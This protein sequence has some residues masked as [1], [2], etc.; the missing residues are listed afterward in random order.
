MKKD[1]LTP[2]VRF[3]A[4]AIMLGLFVLVPLFVGAQSGVLFIQD[5]K[6]GIGTDTPQTL[7]DVVGAGGEVSRTR[8]GAHVVERTDGNA[9][10]IRFKVDNATKTQSWLFMNG[11]NNGI[12]T[13]YDETAGKSAFVAYPNSVSYTLVLRGGKVGVGT[14]TPQAPLD[15]NGAIYQRGV[16]LHA[17]Y[18]FNPDYNL[19]SIEEHTAT[20]WKNKHLPALPKA[21]VDD[22]GLEVINVGQHR[23][24]MLE[25]LEKA[26]VYIAELHERL[27]DKERHIGSLEQ[28]VT[29]L[30]EMLSALA[31]RVDTI[32]QK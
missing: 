9:A 16:E 28:K 29:R 27:S 24:G 12:F 14:N 20:M 8:E 10:N 6:V 7:L 23:R 18:V 19:E 32:E 31:G 22:A 13:I 4:P 15:V 25:E 21:S 2:N 3:L 30:E 26:H 17:D 11:G 5:N 1:T